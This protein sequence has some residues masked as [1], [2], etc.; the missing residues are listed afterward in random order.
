M[1]DEDQVRMV[2]RA[3]LNYRSYQVVEAVDGEDA[4][5]KYTQSPERFDPARNIG[6]RPKAVGAS[7]Q[8]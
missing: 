1:D 7:I 6:D 2:M 5:Q 4:V 3:M 8:P